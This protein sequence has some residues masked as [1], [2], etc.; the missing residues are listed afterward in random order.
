MANRSIGE[1]AIFYK[2]GKFITSPKYSLMRNGVAVALLGIFMW[3]ARQPNTFRGVYDHYQW[4]FTYVILLSLFYSNLYWLVPEFLFKKKIVI[5]GIGLLLLNLAGSMVIYLFHVFVLEP[6]RVVKVQEKPFV[7]LQTIVLAIFLLLIILSSTS[8]KFFKKWISD[9]E[10]INELE[11]RALESE[12]NALRHQIQPHFLFNMLNNINVLTR[13]DP[14]KASNIIVRFSEF[15]RHL[16]YEN[17]HT[18]TALSGEIKFLTDYLNL[19]AM[20]RDDFDYSINYEEENIKNVIL[21][22]NIL[23]VF[24]ENA[25]KH[26]ADPSEGSYIDLRFSIENNEFCFWCTNSI[27]IFTNRNSKSSGI[28]LLNLERRLQLLY[29]DNFYLNSSCNENEYIASLK[30]PL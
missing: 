4:I 28:G 1:I 7:I 30:L 20:R 25:I 19:E 10:K 15:L 17:N 18:E 5:Y 14:A 2:I 12:L 16:L 23:L 21:P 9:I 8:V 6:H 22:P 24:V 3:V 13:K 29:N 26:S 11:R 27:P